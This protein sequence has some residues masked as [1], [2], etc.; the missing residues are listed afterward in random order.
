MTSPPKP[1]TILTPQDGKPFTLENLREGQQY[2]LLRETLFKLPLSGT[3]GLDPLAE[4]ITVLSKQGGRLVLQHDSDYI[5]K[6]GT[7]VRKSESEAMGIVA[8]HTSVSVPRV[9]YA[10][11]FDGSGSVK[12]NIGMTIVPGAPL[13]KSW[14]SLNSETK[15]LV[16]SQTWDLIIKLRAIPPP[17]H[18]EGLF[19]CL[20]DG[21]PTEDPLIE[22]FDQ[23]PRPLHTDDD[24]RS[25][26]YE[27]YLHFGGLKYKDELP[28]MLP[29]SSTSVF[30][31]SDISPRNIM[32]DREHRITGILDW[33]WAG[34]YPDYWEYAQIMRPACR[35][36]DWQQ[37]MD[38]T[39]PQR[40]EIAGITAARKVLF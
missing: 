32:V 26:I 10:Q 37:W 7:A 36:G 6:S 27:R 2:V 14:K 11:F 3:K 38:R 18:L 16:C 22:D 34:W 9:L 40:W 31:H 1:L 24:L 15:E 20:A 4:V 25:R 33:E 30:T 28:K 19:Q 17:T 23:P 21:A 8:K 39:A 12:N 13:E 35:L 29:Q 5:S